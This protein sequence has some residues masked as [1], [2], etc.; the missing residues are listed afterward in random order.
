MGSGALPCPYPSPQAN[1]VVLSPGTLVGQQTRTVGGVS[2]RW[3]EWTAT[4]NLKGI[5]GS[6]VT[7][8]FDAQVWWLPSSGVAFSD[9]ADQPDIT[10]LLS[11][12]RPFTPPPTTTTTTPG[13]NIAFHSPSGNIHCGMQF[14]PAPANDTIHCFTADPP[15]AVTLMPNGSFTTCAGPQCL[16]APSPGETNL[17]YGQA[18]GRGGLQCTSAFT[19]VTCTVNGK[20]FAISRSGIV[21]S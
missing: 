5:A 15:Q 14:G 3:Y 6:P 19:G 4:C 21:P 16:A 17:D 18:V 8:T 7:H 20:G 11:S 12:V 9:V 2:Y 13:S 1:N 10:T